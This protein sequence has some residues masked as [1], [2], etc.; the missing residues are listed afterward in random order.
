MI[1]FIAYIA[2]ESCDVVDRVQSKLHALL[3]EFL[4]ADIV[5]VVVVKLANCHGSR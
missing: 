4:R 3:R 2:V 1:N 5:I